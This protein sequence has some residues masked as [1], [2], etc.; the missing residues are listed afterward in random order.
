MSIN[1]VICLR[2]DP[3][4]T[5]NLYNNLGGV[6]MEKFYQFIKHLQ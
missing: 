3:V 1:L 6:L 2:A 5:G 4:R